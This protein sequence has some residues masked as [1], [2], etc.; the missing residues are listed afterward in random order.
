MK[1]T[2][3]PLDIKGEFCYSTGARGRNAPNCAYA[4]KREIA[5]IATWSLPWSMSGIVLLDGT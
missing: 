5:G 3:F 4:M 2:K 1:N